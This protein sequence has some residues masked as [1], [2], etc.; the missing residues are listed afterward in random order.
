LKDHF[1]RLSSPYVKAIRDQQ[2]HQAT[3]PTSL[4]CIEEGFP[5]KDVNSMHSGG[6]GYESSMPVPGLASGSERRWSRSLLKGVVGGVGGGSH[7]RDSSSEEVDAIEELSGDEQDNSVSCGVKNEGHGHFRGHR[8]VH[9]GS[10]AS[11]RGLDDP[12][13][14]R[15]RVMNPDDGVS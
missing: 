8:Q 13:N 5:Q 2:Q 12:S 14:L 1:K 10:L 9:S 6:N 15:L 3:D 11:F 7:R 4:S